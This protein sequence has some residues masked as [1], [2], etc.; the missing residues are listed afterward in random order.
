MGTWTSSC[1]SHSALSSFASRRVRVASEALR[2]TSA[3]HPHPH[4]A[5][6]T[7]LQ[8]LCQ[9]LPSSS[10]FFVR[11][12]VGKLAPSS[13]RITASWRRRLLTWRTQAS[14]Y[15]SCSLCTSNL[16]P[17]SSGKPT[18][19]VQST[20]TFSAYNAAQGL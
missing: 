2:P 4:P 10:S 6:R 11:L 3:T 1:I 8:T 17:R 7:Q 18:L 12:P 14:L 13:R 5:R 9:F 19:S 20:R 15:A 16:N